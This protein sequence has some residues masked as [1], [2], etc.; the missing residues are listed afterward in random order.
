MHKPPRGIELHSLKPSDIAGT[1]G[2]QLQNENVLDSPQ[3]LGVLCINCGNYILSH[4]LIA[5]SEQCVVPQE[6]KD[7]FVAVR[8]KLS[9]LEDFISRSVAAYPR[10]GDKNYLKIL[11]RL[12][13]NL[14]TAYT[15]ESLPT[16]C[17]VGES[18]SSLLTTF[19]GSDSLKLYGERLKA[20]VFECEREVKMTSLK[21]EVDSLKQEVEF[22]RT[23]AAA[24]EKSMTSAHTHFQTDNSR[25]CIDNLNSDVGSRHSGTS[26]SS[27]ENTSRCEFELEQPRQSVI[28]DLKRHFYSQCLVI[29]LTFPQ[30]SAAHQVPISQMFRQVVEQRIPADQWPE[31]IK[32]RLLKASLVPK[33]AQ[34]SARWS[35]MSTLH[36]DE[37]E[38]ESDKEV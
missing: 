16:V 4:E 29:K 28:A 10:P 3:E 7:S 26:N 35:K 34:S 2:K 19:R 21:L 25:T 14:L 31:F 30:K 6:E 18:V 38:Q 17:Q 9:K 37:R 32:S 23:K 11:V 22:Y 33:P 36:E 27:S 20:L 13:K 1:I 8:A 15:P 5:H 24:L 12:C